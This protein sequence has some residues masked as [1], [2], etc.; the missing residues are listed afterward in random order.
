MTI[1]TNLDTAVS[2][3]PEIPREAIKDYRDNTEAMLEDVNE[4]LSSRDD[5]TDLIGDNPLEIMVD[6]HQNHIQFMTNVF[7]LNDYELLVRTVSWVYRTYKNHGFYYDYFPVELEAW[8]DAVNEHLSAQNAKPIREVY[9]FML[10][11]HQEF[12]D[13]AQSMV[14]LEIDIPDKWEGPADELLEA[15]LHGDQKRAVKVAEENVNS[16]DDVGSFFEYVIRPSMYRVGNK[17]QEDEISVA[18]EHLASSIISRVISKLYSSFVTFEETKGKAVVTAVAN[19]FHEIGSR[20]ISDSLELDGWDVDHLGVDTP[21]SDLIDLLLKRKPF[22]LGLSLAIPFNMD[23]VVETIEMVKDRPEL[24][25][26]KVL[27]GGKAFNDNP[28]LWE[29]T[30]ADAWCKDSREAVEVARD[31]W[32]GQTVEA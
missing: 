2:G 10:E 26:V 12:V 20:I 23:K 22:L 19:E 8:I 6:N 30:G 15:L 5:I 4:E 29:E 18:E 7:K 24:Y 13:M 1:P 11:N 25:D 16:G 21:E 28:E 17:W 9:S 14:A 32:R 3:L 27:I 31:W